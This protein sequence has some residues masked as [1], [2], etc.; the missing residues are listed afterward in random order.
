[1]KQHMKDLGRAFGI[2]VLLLLL[3]SAFFF[4]YKHW[5]PKKA[6]HLETIYST[7]GNKNGT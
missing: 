4:A 6:V 2:K 3:L 7:K 5:F 1:M